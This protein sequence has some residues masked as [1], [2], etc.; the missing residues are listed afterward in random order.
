MDN[1]CN[2]SGLKLL[3]ICQSTDIKIV[4]G[5]FGDDAEIGQFTFMSSLGESLID[6]ALMSQGLFPLINNFIVHDFYS[7]STHAP[8]QLDLIV[9]YVINDDDENDDNENI[10][11]SK[12]SWDNN[13]AGEFLEVLSSLVSSLNSVVN[14]I[15]QENLDISAG[16]DTFADTLYN[17]SF[18]IF[19]NTQGRARSNISRKECKF[20]SPWYTKECKEA[21]RGIKT[22]NKNNGKYRSPETRNEVIMKRRLY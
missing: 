12:L 20:L 13:K 18:S 11:L 16:I 15:I 7:C 6:F 22:A 19:G 4:N 9:N 21:R 14:S 3:D 2:S 17:A 10:R 8:I 1:T 5:R